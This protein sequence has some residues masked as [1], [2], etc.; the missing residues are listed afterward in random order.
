MLKRLE[1]TEENHHELMAY[2]RQKNIEFLSTPF[3]L[4]S[5]DL[6]KNLGITIG[7]VPS[8]ELTN[9]PYL[10]KMAQTFEHSVYNRSEFTKTLNKP[11]SKL[12]EGVE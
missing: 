6:L 4:P 2:A 5:I 11:D 3:D 1:L 7:K 12:M 10:R 9:L 8:G